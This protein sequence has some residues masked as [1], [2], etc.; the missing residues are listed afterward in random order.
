M[1]GLIWLCLAYVLSQ[2]FRAFLAVLSTVLEQDI[3]VSAQNLADA[4]GMWFLAFAL[5]QLPVGWALDRIGPR[6]TA[7]VLL[8]IGGA[9][10]TA[11]F[12]L[13]SGPGMLGLAMAL[14]GIGCSPVL[15]A[16]YYIFA[17]EYPPRHFA[18]LGALM[19][20]VGSVG[21]LIASY[22]TALAAELIGWRGTMLLLCAASAAVAVGLFVTVRDPA[23]AEGDHRGSV[24]D[25]LKLPVLWLI[26]PMMFV[27][28]APSGTLRGLWIGP[29]LA[30]VFGMDTARIG[31]ATLVMGVAMI[32][33][34]LAYGPMDRL[35]RSRKWPIAVGGIGTAAALAALSLQIDNTPAL[36]L[37]LMAAVGV[38]GG[39]FPVIIAHGR[40]FFPAHLVGRGVTLMNLFGIGGVG[41]MQLATGRLH[42]ATEAQGLT[43]P[44]VAIFLF[45]ALV[46]VLGT[47][48]YLFSRDSLD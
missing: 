23:P 47:A 35:C 17:R 43:A 34:T 7:S 46:T 38:F 15:M 22:P 30:D 6:R 44:Y 10:G 29:Y 24:L 45:L 26:L 8:L 1:M 3:G 39:Y 36:S 40:A 5:M 14:I 13:A 31:Q 21:N 12:S 19:L 25:L 32:L 28:Y 48:V 27:S 4:S 33:G 16:S 2:F 37:A 18:T 20:G 11:L 41:L 42:A 9:G